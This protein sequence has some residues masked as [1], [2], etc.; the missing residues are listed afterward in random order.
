MF[1]EGEEIQTLSLLTTNLKQKEILDLLDEYYALL[2]EDW[3]DSM[4]KPNNSKPVILDR[5]FD[6]L[7][8]QKRT[9]LGRFGSR[10]EYLKGYYMECC[11]M[12]KVLPN[13]KF[14]LQIDTSI[15]EDKVLRTLDLSSCN[16]DNPQLEF[17]TKSIMK[18]LVY[19]HETAFSWKENLDFSDF[20]LDNNRIQIEAAPN[21][22]VFLIMFFYIS[23]QARSIRSI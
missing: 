5:P 15:D 11:A 16:I 13:K 19:Q 8:P 21:L 14:C 17:I 9:F 1:E 10:L 4:K 18:A 7:P 23:L 12:S 22:Y 2:P 3:R 6:Y 20:L